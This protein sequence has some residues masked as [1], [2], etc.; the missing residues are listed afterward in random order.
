MGGQP[1]AALACLNLAAILLSCLSTRLLML[2]ECSPVFRGSKLLCQ[3]G[4][5]YLWAALQ[6]AVGGKC[7]RLPRHLGVAGA[8]YI[9]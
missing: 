8:R 1:H 7:V 9:R 3:S 4:R 6:H 5:R 2:S